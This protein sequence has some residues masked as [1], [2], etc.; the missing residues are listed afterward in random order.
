MKQV[1]GRPQD[2]ADIAELEGIQKLKE[3]GPDD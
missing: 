3:S 1:A 2:L